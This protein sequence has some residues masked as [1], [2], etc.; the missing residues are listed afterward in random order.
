MLPLRISRSLDLVSSILKQID[1]LLQ[2]FQ[3]QATDL[4]ISLLDRRLISTLALKSKTLS[5]AVYL[6]KSQCNSLRFWEAVRMN[7]LSEGRGFHHQPQQWVRTLKRCWWTLSKI[8]KS[9]SLRTPI[10]LN[11]DL[12]HLRGGNI[13]TTEWVLARVLKPRP[14]R[15]HKTATL[16]KGS[17][18]FWLVFKLR[19]Q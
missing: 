12:I 2:L 1:S 10:K 4:S 11:L 14:Q 7:L 16:G 3:R 17:Q 9:L 13:L 18:L 8:S 19:S 5:K 15:P 6:V